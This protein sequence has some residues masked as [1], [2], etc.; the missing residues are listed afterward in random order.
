MAA[1]YGDML[2]IFSN[3]YMADLFGCS[4]GLCNHLIQ[5]KLKQRVVHYSLGHSM[6]IFLRFRIITLRHLAIK[7]KRSTF[8]LSHLAIAQSIC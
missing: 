4:I 7:P 3:L 1:L 5:A 6:T 8:I 2:S